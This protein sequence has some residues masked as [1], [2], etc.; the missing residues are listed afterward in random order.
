MSSYT[1]Y[2]CVCACV[3]ACVR[4]CVCV[5]LR[6]EVVGIALLLGVCVE[7]TPNELSQLHNL[8]NTPASHRYSIYLLY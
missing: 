1:G 5:Q 3:R 4:V 6:R 2:V 7:Q 8:W